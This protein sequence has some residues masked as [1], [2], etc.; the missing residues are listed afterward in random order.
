MGGVGTYGHAKVE[1][2]KGSEIST[3]ERTTASTG[4]V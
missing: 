1:E 2:K 3:Q 4:Y